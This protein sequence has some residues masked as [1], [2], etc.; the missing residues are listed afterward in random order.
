MALIA[1][2]GLMQMEAMEKPASFDELHHGE[3]PANYGHLRAGAVGIDGRPHEKVDP[4]VVQRLTQIFGHHRSLEEQEAL[5]ESDIN[6][7]WFGVLKGSNQQFLHYSNR[8]INIMRESQTGDFAERFP[9]LVSFVGQTG[10]GKSTVIKM[11]IDREQACTNTR[12]H[13]ADIFSAP[14]TG[15]VNDNIPTTGDVHLYSDP[16]TY[17][18]RRPI[19]Y[20]DCEGMSGGE[21]LPR[22]VACKE[23]LEAAKATTRVAKSKLRKPLEWANGA[24]PQSREYAVKRLYPRILY[25]FSDVVVFVLREVR[26]F[27]TEVLQKLVEWAYSS[28][29]KSINQP[30]LPHII[31]AL[32]ATENAIDEKQWDLE[33]A[34]EKLLDDYKDSIHQ[35]QKLQNIVASLKTIDKNISSTKE[36]LEYYYSSI[37]VVRIPTK[38]RYMLIDDQIG[39]LHAVIRQK[40]STSFAHKKSVRMLLN[41]ERLQQYVNSAYDHFSRRLDEPFDFVKEA[42]RHNPM[43]RDFRGHILNL[44]LSIYNDVDSFKD[45][46]CGEK[47]L[48]LLSRPIASCVMLA[49][50]RE[51]LQGSY[52]TLLWN[53]FYMPIKAAYDEFC[54]QWLRCGFSQNGS[55]CCVVKNLHKK[56]HQARSGKIFSKGSYSP[57]FSSDVF[58]ED[59]M[60]DIGSHLDKL[61]RKLNEFGA[62]VQEREL[63]ARLHRTE[64]ETFYRKLDSVTKVKSHATC[65]CC[66]RKVPE[67]VLPCGHV[68]CDACVQSIG[69]DVGGC[70]FEVR[71]CPLHPQYAKWYD[72]PVRIKF[73]PKDAG[74]R[75]L[76]LDGGGI[77]GI[78]ELVILRAIEKELGDLIPVQ[79]FFDLIVGTSTGGIVALGLGVKNWRV[80]ICIAHFKKLCKEAFTARPLKRLA[81]VS[82]KSYYKSTPF[83][84][85]LKA[86]FDDQSLLFGGSSSELRTPIK[87]AVTSTAATENRPVILTNYNSSG[88]KREK[89]PYQFLRSQD[90]ATELKLWEAARATSAAP[91]YFKPF[92]KAETGVPFTDGAIHHN[93]PAW[94][95][96]CERQV[97]WEDVRNRQPDILLSLGTGLSSQPLAQSANVE[98]EIK[99]AERTL[100][101]RSTSGFTYMWRTAYGILDSQLN[102]EQTWRDFS[103]KMLPRGWSTEEEERRYMRI[104]VQLKGDRP[105]LDQVTELQSLEDQAV[106]SI[107]RNPDIRETAHRLVASSF[108]YE[109]HSGI[110][111]ELNGNFTTRGYIRCRFD[112]GS[113]DIKGLGQILRNCYNGDFEPF[114]LLQENYGLADETYKEFAIPPA[115]LD[116]MCRRGLFDMSTEVTVEASIHSSATRMALCL[117]EHSYLKSGVP[118]AE[119]YLSI[120]GFPREIF[121][122]EVNKPLPP[123]PEAEAT[124]PAR[125]AAADGASTSVP[126]LG[127]ATGGA[128]SPGSNSSLSGTAEQQQQQQQQPGGVLSRPDSASTTSSAEKDHPPKQRS[129]IFSLGRN[130]TLS[131]LS[132]RGRFASSR[133]KSDENKHRPHPHS[134]T[135]GSTTT[136]VASPEP[137]GTPMFTAPLRSPRVDEEEEEEDDEESKQS[138]HSEERPS[139]D[140]TPLDDDESRG[141]SWTVTVGIDDDSFG[142]QAARRSGG[143]VGRTKTQTLGFGLGVLEVDIPDTD[144]RLF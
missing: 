95:A 8:L 77:R 34:T 74:V 91:L 21:K 37:T 105:N 132:L 43:P 85:A 83:E 128:T 129:G 54:E 122:Q 19:L 109:R 39:K 99:R 75:L 30:N 47:L 98:A 102:S 81:L 50:A 45:R 103:N 49:A 13:H 63:V 107:S 118:Q 25:T 6:T 3:R 116:D 65:L 125:K 108:Y 42:L 87:V 110:H 53:T 57:E 123:V 9:H 51:D 27:E 60:L 7:T 22:G 93:C 66:V 134:H 26:T 117:Q 141:E 28:I 62:D 137:L 112:K 94:V 130:S 18:G 100:Q 69:D 78:V 139:A 68:L 133:P 35:V 29:D 115:T 92:I 32:N 48:R 135:R 61:I 119:R 124:A 33:V 41:A 12:P 10:A 46:R 97:L 101:K 142:G 2:T 96:N 121:T 90:P 70:V 56:G 24:K 76:C 40:C 31:I 36:L 140:A 111:Q 1:I 59:W 144:G 88:V 138:G 79:N 44:M 72:N 20:A 4:E 80:S 55:T 52:S 38:G 131:D 64:I 17:S 11:L 84:L 58:F 23:K 114:F 113:Q 136:L 5:H 16:S 73:K 126:I 15:L 71:Y 104:N 143:S 86:T 67:H 82:H 106:Q 127:T 89:L 120:S 14:V